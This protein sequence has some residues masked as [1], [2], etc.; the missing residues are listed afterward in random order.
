MP[1]S[2]PA[3]YGYFHE[4]EEHT[5]KADL[6]LGLILGDGRIEKRGDSITI[7]IELL[8]QYLQDLSQDCFDGFLDESD[9]LG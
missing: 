4:V 2:T 8:Y 3:N 9:K 6:F 7:S 5:E 1:F